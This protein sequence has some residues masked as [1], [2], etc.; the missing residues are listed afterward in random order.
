M[1]G[2]APPR[3]VLGALASI[4]PPTERTIDI[5]L[6]SH[7]ELDHFGGF[8]DILKIYDV[9]LFV[10]SGR[11]KDTK[12]YG[13]LSAL[14]KNKNIPWVTLE[15]GDSIDYGD[16][17]FA[18]LGPSPAELK[19]KAVN[20]SS[21]VLMLTGPYFSALYTGDIGEATE[22]RLVKDYDLD[23]DILKVPHHGSR[24]SSS[25]AF[26]SEITPL[27]AITEVGRNSYGH[28]TKETLSRLGSAA[29]TILRTDQ[30]GTITLMSTKEGIV[31]EK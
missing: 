22:R 5:L 2:G 27:Y 15:E 12:S 25:E 3:A 23:I 9:R 29:E 28:P 31:Q 7:P 26:L 1:R 14:V 20:E 30:N 16:Y 18:V 4:L 24:F 21:L 17:H 10:S 8:I 11:T 6:M 19:N 13:E